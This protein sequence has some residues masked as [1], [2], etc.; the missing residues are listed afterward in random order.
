[1][2]PVFNSFLA[3]FL[4]FCPKDTAP[5]PPAQNLHCNMTS[6]VYVGWGGTGLPDGRDHGHFPEKWMD[7][8][9]K[10]VAVSG[11][12]VAVKG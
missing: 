9:E 3:S 12:K 6:A 1:M 4:I 10:F 7:G 11:R 8:R 5:P 2:S